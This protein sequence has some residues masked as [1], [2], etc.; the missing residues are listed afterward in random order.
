MKT[1]LIMRHAK[2]SWKNLSLPDHDRP[3]NDRGEEDAPRIGAALKS[4]DL[5]PTLILTSTAQRAVQTAELVADTSGYEKEVRRDRNLFHAG[6][7]EFLESLQRVRDD[8]NIVLVVGH[9][10]GVSELVDYLTDRPETMTTA[11]VAV[12]NLPIESWEDLDFNT[13][14]ELTRILRPREL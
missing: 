11:N 4:L 5:T 7:D 6:V 10:P 8:E 2:S 12:V 9:N 14:G 13:E 3:L 1:L